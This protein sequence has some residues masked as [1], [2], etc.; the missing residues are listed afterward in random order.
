MKITVQELISRLRI[1][2]NKS[3]FISV[4]GQDINNI[5]SAVFYYLA[6]EQV[7][8]TGQARQMFIRALNMLHS[9]LS[10]KS[11]TEFYDIWGNFPERK[12]YG[13]NFQLETY[14]LGF[15]FSTEDIG[16]LSQ[17]SSEYTTPRT[18]TLDLNSARATELISI[19]NSRYKGI[20]GESYQKFYINTILYYAS[21][22]ITG[23][24]P[25]QLP[26]VQ[27]YKDKY[28]MKFKNYL[29]GK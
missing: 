27:Q 7:V 18:D 20:L 12:Q 10:S 4:F 8:D 1:A 29:I 3:S 21:G 16:V 26:Y 11:E 22:T 28:L 25:N 2:G 14:D 13:G 5:L 19:R 15:K 24:T 9:P 17:N 23:K 6:L